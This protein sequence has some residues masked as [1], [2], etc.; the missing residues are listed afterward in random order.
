MERFRLI[1]VAVF[2]C[3]LVG[4]IGGDD[5]EEIARLEAELEEINS[6]LKAALAESIELSKEY[7][8]KMR[9]IREMDYNRKRE[10][11]MKV[12]H[13]P[14]DDYAQTLEGAI[15]YFEKELVIWKEATRDSLKG[16]KVTRIETAT[17]VV[18]ENATV[19]AVTDDKVT[20]Q[21]ATGTETVDFE[22]LPESLRISLV[23]E[24][25]ILARSALK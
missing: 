1:V 3:G 23:H 14:V 10:S 22:T 17:G 9:A 19:S 2:C 15:S 5:P 16:M 13:Q 18:I 20:F 21:T 6:N 8:R 4:C 11:S 12:D 25:T 7:D 24:P